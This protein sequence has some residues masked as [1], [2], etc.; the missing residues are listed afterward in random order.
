MTKSGIPTTVCFTI[1]PIS[2][3]WKKIRPGVRSLSKGVSYMKKRRLAITAVFA[4]VAIA[5]TGC[6]STDEAADGFVGVILPDAA[7][8]N[9]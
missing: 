7:S 9:R 6:S 1:A 2:S 8:S 4:A 3:G 5:L